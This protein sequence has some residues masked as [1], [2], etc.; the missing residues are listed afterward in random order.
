MGWFWHGAFLFVTPRAASGAFLEER[1]KT[2]RL[3]ADAYGSRATTATER[4]M[5]SRK[6]ASVVVDEPWGW[7]RDVRAA[8]FWWWSSCLSRQ[9]Y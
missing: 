4:S 1:P 3:H 5:L 9:A 2:Q 8:P 7:L 6:K